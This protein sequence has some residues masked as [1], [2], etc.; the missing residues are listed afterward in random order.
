M[1][2]I[3]YIPESV[4][5]LP[6]LQ[7][8]IGTGSTNEGT[9]GGTNCIAIHGTLVCILSFNVAG[10]AAGGIRN[11]RQSGRRLGEILMLVLVLE[12]GLFL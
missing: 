12:L 5:T 9:V 10:L 1:L 7:V 8:C 3:C 2:K 4:R 11:N 6:I